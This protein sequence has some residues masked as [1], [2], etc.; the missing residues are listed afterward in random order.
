MTE[1]AA[2]S[3]AARGTLNKRKSKHGSTASGGGLNNGLHA[4]GMPTSATAAPA[5]DQQS[6]QQQQWFGS[7]QEWQ[8]HLP[9]R[10]S[11]WLWQ[12]GMMLLVAAGLWLSGQLAGGALH[13]Q[14]SVARLE[15]LVHGLVHIPSPI[16]MPRVVENDS[17]RGLS[18]LENADASRSP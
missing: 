5:H 3:S 15:R 8:K 12:A 2:S 9:S 4:P 13:L 11:T 1:N 14:C 16:A 18:G 10:T 6:E 7:E 17:P